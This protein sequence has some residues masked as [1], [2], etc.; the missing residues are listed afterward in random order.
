MDARPDDHAR[1][2]L[3]HDLPCPSCGHDHWA[4]PCEAVA[5]E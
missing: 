2:G 5:G 4:L 1:P 3:S